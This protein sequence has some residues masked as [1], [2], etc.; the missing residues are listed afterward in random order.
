MKKPYWWVI[1]I[2]CVQV[3]AVLVLMPG[4]SVQNSIA[5][6]TEYLTGSFGSSARQE[7]VEKAASWHGVLFYDSGFYDAAMELLIPSQEQKNSSRGISTMGGQWFS[8]VEGRIEAISL[9]LYYFLLRLSVVAM[10]MPYMLVLLVP[11]L[12]DGLMTWKIK[13]ANF[14]YASPVI[15]RYSLRLLGVLSV[16]QLITFFLPFAMPPI[17]IPLSLTV[18]CVLLGMVLGNMQKRI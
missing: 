10:W 9:V 18:A 15:H 1:L 6:E 7:L 8:Y 4:R 17:F 5:K 11:A 13:R 16:C 14:Q 2:L 3:V 12:Y